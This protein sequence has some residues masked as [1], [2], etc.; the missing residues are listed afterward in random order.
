[1]SDFITFLKEQENAPLA[2]GDL[3]KIRHASP[4]GGL[5]TIGFGH[6]ITKAEEQAGAVHG[7]PIDQIDSMEKVEHILQLDVAAKR[8]TLDRSLRKKHGV[9]LG[10]L[11]PRKQA[12]LLDYEFNL[13]SAVKKFP[14]FTGAVLSGDEAVQKNEFMRTFK[15]DKGERHPLARN[16]AF[17]NNFMSSEA[18]AAWGEQ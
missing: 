3:S 4:E 10:S 13:G 8:K 11:S 2:T 16:G 14:T 12:M 15:D 7:I 18:K 1:M 5:D 6:K 9:A 17:Y